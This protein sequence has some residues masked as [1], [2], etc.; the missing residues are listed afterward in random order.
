MEEFRRIR[1]EFLILLSIFLLPAVYTSSGAVDPELFNTVHAHFGLLIQNV[2]R[3][4]LLLY[5]MELE[6]YGWKD[7]YGLRLHGSPARL[8]IPATGVT[9]VLLAVAVTANLLASIIGAPGAP[10]FEFN[11][12][13]P[14][15]YALSGFSLLSVGYMEELFFRSYVITRLQQLG[16]SNRNAL[17]YSAALFSLG[18]LY[19]GVQGVLFALLAGVALGAIYLRWNRLHPLALGHAVYNYLGLLFS[20]LF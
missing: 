19:Q 15:I 20:G 12:P 11:S 5:L 10:P 6:G 2:P 18:H 4:L 3:I 13:T 16:S 14:L 17:L 9:G 7:R 8:V 1:R